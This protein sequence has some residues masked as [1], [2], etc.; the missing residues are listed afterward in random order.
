MRRQHTG[1]DMQTDRDIEIRADLPERFPYFIMNARQTFQRWIVAEGDGVAAF[2][3][4]PFDLFDHRSDVPERQ[5]R[6]GNETSGISAAPLVDMPVI[7]GAD[8]H[9]GVRLVFILQED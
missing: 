9:L 7:I 1:A 5:D 4:D 2:G 8:E 6:A 3:G